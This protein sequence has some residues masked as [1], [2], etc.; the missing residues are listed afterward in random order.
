MLHFQGLLLRES[1]GF[2]VLSMIVCQKE[3]NVQTI[4][5]LKAQLLNHY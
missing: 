5:A 3:K 4:I 2:L 1:Q